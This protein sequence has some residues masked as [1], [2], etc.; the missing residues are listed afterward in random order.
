MSGGAAFIALVEVWWFGAL[1][2]AV[3][4]SDTMFFFKAGT[5]QF[6]PSFQRWILASYGRGCVLCAFLDGI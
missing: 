6:C 2:P 4:V 5:A 1:A 3:V